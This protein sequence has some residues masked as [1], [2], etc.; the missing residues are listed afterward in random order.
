MSLDVSEHPVQ[1]GVTEVLRESPVQELI[2]RVFREASVGLVITDHVGR[3]VVINDAFCN[4]TGYS[5]EELAQRDFASITHPSD[6]QP[7]VQLKDAMRTGQVCT[8]VFEKRYIRKDGETVWTRLNVTLL[9]AEDGTSPRFLTLAEDISESKRA[10]ES[11]E[12]S[13]KRYRAL[14]ENALEIILL[15]HRDGT[16]LY[17][18]PSITR[19]LGYLVEEFVGRNAYEFIHPDDWPAVRQ[20][21][22]RTLIN[23]WETTAASFRVR[24]KNG[25]WR[26]IEG[27]GQN[28]E[29]LAAVQAIVVNGRDVTERYQA[30]QQIN[31]ANR[32]LEKALTVA[33][34]ATELKSRFLA[35]MS[36]EIRTPMNGILGMSELLLGTHL[37]VEQQEYAD[38][39]RKSTC[40]LLTIIN[41]I[42]D[43]SKIEAGKLTLEAIPFSLQEAV[44]DVAAL[45]GPIATEAGIGFRTSIKNPAIHAVCGDPVRFRQVLINLM[46]N[47]VKFTKK[48]EVRLTVESYPEPDR[49]IR[50]CCRVEDTG[51]GI[52]CEQLTHVFESFCQ[53]D[54][55][56]TRKFGGTGLGLP[57]SREL[58]RLMHGDL[59][60]ESILGVGTAF[61]FTAVLGQSDEVA[62]QPSVTPQRLADATPVSGRI[63][64]AEDNEINARIASRMLSKAGYSAIVVADGQQAVEAARCGEWDLVLMDIQMPV[65]D[66]FEATRAIRKLPRS[67]G[68][69]IVALTANAMSGD[70][71]QCLAER[72]G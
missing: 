37:D 29:S 44:D 7:N 18:S 53:G 2:L 8:A 33:R 65:L 5:R 42:L 60:C 57:I 62:R 20:K 15:L 4:M 66:G 16:L 67:A 56:T 25:D 50:I 52:P 12:L 31:A 35:N 69:P 59:S 47:A 38:C 43:I 3:F 64:I 34:E 19:V 48:G 13:E 22:A 21:V 1:H 27:T 28:L 11:L 6:R 61:T 30:E 71:E 72:H 40:S 26:V 17:A 32:E 23:E 36:H 45:I 10:I 70:R 9:R 39:I 24:N 63:L 58:A 54:N 41:D 51:I 55:S 14:I 46:G 49:K 68:V